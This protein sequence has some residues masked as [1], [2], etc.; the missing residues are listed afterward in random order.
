MAYLK[1]HGVYEPYRNEVDFIYLKKGYF[2]SVFNYVS[3]ST[4]PRKEVVAEI[5][6]EMIKQVPDYASNVYYKKKASLRMLDWL[7]VHCTGLALK[8]I[9]VYVRRTN[10]VV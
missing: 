6:Q 10:Q 8:I 9:P 5:R 4:E 3:N 7:L 2:S 1:E